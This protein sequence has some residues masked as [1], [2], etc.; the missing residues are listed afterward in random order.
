MGWDTVE[1]ERL[2]LADLLDDLDDP[3][4]SAPSTCGEW[5]VQEVVAHLVWLAEASHRSM[6]ADAVRV[7]SSFHKSVDEMAR[8]IAASASPAELVARLR[9]GAG[10]RYVAPAMP[11][12]LA[13]GEV[14]IHRTDVPG[15]PA[16]AADETMRSVL[17]AERR[18]WF[19]FGVPRK[20]RRL[21]FRPTDA[22]WSVGPTDG[23]LVEGPGVQLLRAVSGRAG[24]TDGLVGPGVTLLR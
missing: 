24:A 6:L 5:R 11:V 20:V 12:E 17:E 3:A 8:R 2:A 9:A 22:D 14:M 19:A 7:R 15:L 21:H 13:L 1:A 18:V 23:P 4:W 16:R 10:G